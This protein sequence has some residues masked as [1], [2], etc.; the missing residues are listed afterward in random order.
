MFGL[1]AERHAAGHHDLEVPTGGEEVGYLYSSADHLLK[2][3]QEEEHL[4]FS[5]SSFH[6]G[7]QSLLTT[8]FDVEHLSNCRDDQ[9]RIVNRGQIDEENSIWERLAH[10]SDHLQR[11]PGLASTTRSGESQQ[12]HILTA[13]QSGR[14][15]HFPRSPDEGC[16]LA[17]EVI[18][19]HIKGLKRG[20]VGG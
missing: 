19:E 8:V 5:K 6:D 17:R 14:G 18:G 12:M 20:E 15:R 11:Q 10:V 7:Q 1:D 9:F 3:V 13:Q 2:V 16:R 4:L